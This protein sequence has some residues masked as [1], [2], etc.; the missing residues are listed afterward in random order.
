ME[1]AKIP[2][3]MLRLEIVESHLQTN[4]PWLLENLT[5]FRDAGVRIA[6]DDFGTGFSNLQYLT[7]LPID[8]IKIDKAFLKGIITSDKHSNDLLKAIV[9]IGKIFKYTLIAEGVEQESEAKHLASLG[10]A[11]MQGYFY[12]KPM[13]PEDFIAHILRGNPNLAPVT[14]LS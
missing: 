8:T 9:G 4:N 7:A 11:L 1:E 6:I 12:G 10:C 14:P 5:V 2:P 13:R 3:S